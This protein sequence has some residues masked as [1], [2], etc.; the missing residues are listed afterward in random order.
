MYFMKENVTE[1]LPIFRGAK[2]LS[3]YHIH[4]NTLLNA[5]Y[6]FI[7]QYSLIEVLKRKKFR[8]LL[9]CIPMQLPNKNIV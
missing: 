7:F 5:I 6:K 8:T 3:D 1:K 9:I 2:P 4:T